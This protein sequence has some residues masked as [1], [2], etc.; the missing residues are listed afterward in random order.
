MAVESR[1]FLEEMQALVVSKH[2]K[3]HPLFDMIQRGE[4]SKEQLFG[5]VKQFY[6]LFPKPFPKPIAAMFA[7]SPE[8]SELERM[9]MENLDEEMAGGQTGTAGHKDLYLN[10]AA[11]LG[12]SREEMDAV[13]PLPETRALL[14]WR[15]LMVTQRSWMELYAS[16]GMALEG[17]ASGRMH[18]VVDGLVDHYGFVRDS[19]DILYWTVHMAVDE[20]HMKVGP[21]VVEKYAISDLEQQRVRETLNGTLDIFWLVF[22]GIVRAFIDGDPLYSAWREQ[23]GA[24]A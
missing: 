14:A 19:D 11:A 18:K 7:R 3:N 5:F 9:W 12:I 21:Y 24:K 22:D 6:L 4:L 10:F 8:D 2:S 17:T 16:Q 1:K 23:A 20:E 15:E 13:Q